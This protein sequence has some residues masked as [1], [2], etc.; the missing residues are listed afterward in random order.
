M[1]GPKCASYTVDSAALIAARR[2]SAAQA[3]R[4]ALIDRID[5]L[6]AAL[7]AR[8]RLGL[9]DVSEWRLTKTSAKASTGEIEVWNV[10]AQA[11]L[12]R[13]ESELDEVEQSEH[14]QAMR[15]R[16]ADVSSSSA[17]ERI[18][19]RAAVEAACDDVG[20]Q[21][22]ETEN[23]CGPPADSI[24]RDAEIAALIDRL[25]IGAT[26]EERSA[27]DRKISM[28]ANTTTV[29]FDSVAIA[30]KAEIQRVERA[31][32]GRVEERRRAEGLLTTLEGL[33]G[34]EMDES[35]ALLCRVIA[36]STPLL[37]A[38]VRRMTQARTA[39]AAD[40]ERRFVATK[41][42]DALRD[43]GI[44]VGAE[45][46]TDMIDGGRAY[47][48]ARSS[49]EHAVEVRLRDGL[50]DLRLVRAEGA[51]D[52]N[53]DRDAEV[54]FCKDVGRVSAAMHASGVTL[55]TVS[56]RPPGSV[57]V[58]VVPGA[59]PAAEARPRRRA[60]PRERTRER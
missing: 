33:E 16:L 47:A 1:S 23:P 6:N 22:A 45:F 26:S 18:R 27:I 8:Q 9:P 19:H 5:T 13:A 24:D 21:A 46:A 15:R 55:E 10:E 30:A 56:H 2:R 4:D 35:R 38:D 44:D 59:R 14:Q 43:S 60:K 36:G 57:A 11:A 7:S 34:A 37:D 39:A 52:A 50:V 49:D 17:A 41:I 12:A 20:Q 25:P 3:V 31:I 54:E 48:A 51:S 28:L 42:E 29:E 40:F 32:A 53:R 58:E